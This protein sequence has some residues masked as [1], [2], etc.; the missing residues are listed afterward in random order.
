SFEADPSGLQI[1]NAVVVEKSGTKLFGMES[2]NKETKLNSTDKKIR[3]YI[4]AW[5]DRDFTVTVEEKKRYKKSMQIQFV[6]PDP[7]P[8]DNNGKSLIHWLQFVRTYAYKGEGK[9]QTAAD[10]GNYEEAVEFA[11]GDSYGFKWGQT[12]IDTYFPA[13]IKGYNHSP[14]YEQNSP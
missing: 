11:S 6:T 10:I 12:R 13:G 4:Q 9:A 3:G 1:G 7:I 8:F 5:K 14:Y 2:T